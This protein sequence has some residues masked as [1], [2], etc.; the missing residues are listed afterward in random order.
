MEEILILQ[1]LEFEI[2]AAAV[3][4]KSIYGLQSQIEMNEKNVLY[5]MHEMVQNG[6]L[7]AENQSFRIEEPFRT[8]I[9]GI[10]EADRLLSVRAEKDFKR[11][12]CFYLGEKLVTLEESESDEHAIRIGIYE[13][14][15][16]WKVMEE[17]D[18]VPK[19]RVPIDIARLQTEQELVD[20]L[21]TSERSQIQNQDQIEFVSLQNEKEDDYGGTVQIFLQYLFFCPKED[22]I[23]RGAVY[24]VNHPYNYWIVKKKA[25][26]TEF[27][28]YSKEE[29]YEC[30]NG[31][32]EDC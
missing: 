20:L 11:N 5:H 9:I 13:R 23:A 17:R 30:I 19:E 1:Q 4:I 31:F 24:L 10:K 3:G 28:C 7:R 26:K 14:E 6:I 22:R 8:A 21:K 18:F 32:L 29:M 27:L 12:C 16:F 15:N 25:E 2:L